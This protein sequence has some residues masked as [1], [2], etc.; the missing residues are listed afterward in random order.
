M[1]IPSV[2]K[3]EFLRKFTLFNPII[4]PE[5][6]FNMLYTV[7]SLPNVIL[8]FLGGFLVDKIGYRK[9]TVILSCILAFGQVL[10]GLSI[11]LKSVSL[12][13]TGR[14]IFGLGGETLNITVMTI[15]YR[16]FNGAELAFAQ[17][18]REIY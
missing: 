9:M 14:F 18:K 7:Y 17:V 8:P 4:D 13:V 11:S 5:Y 15:L 12:M 1:D 2:L 16:W 6:V 3:D 10:Q